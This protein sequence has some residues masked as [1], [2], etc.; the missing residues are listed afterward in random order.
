MDI[1]ELDRQL[2]AA[3]LAS[4]FEYAFDTM[5]AD[6]VVMQENSSPPC[7][8]KPANRKRQEY[9]G[10]VAECLAVR[11]LS[12]AVSG[13]KSFSEWEFDINYQGLR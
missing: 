2:N 13:D 3:L 9:Y 5:Y 6:D 8:G 10:T 12:S 4:R 11:L 1:A 7:V